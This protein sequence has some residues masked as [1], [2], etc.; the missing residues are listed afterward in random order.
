MIII[1]SAILMF[2]T[3]LYFVSLRRPIVYES[4]VVRGE[5]KLYF[6]YP[7]T[8][9]ILSVVG[10]HR[11][12]QPKN[13]ISDSIK[14]LKL[15]SRPEHQ[16]RLYLN[17]KL[18]LVIVILALFSALSIVSDVSSKLQQLREGRYIDRPEHG[19][20]SKE[21]MLDLRMESGEEAFSKD[22]NELSRKITIEV[23]ER[24]YSR[25]E[26]TKL[27][28]EGK[29]YLSEHVLGENENAEAIN[30]R[31]L[32]MDYVPNTEI[33][34]EWMPKDRNLILGD[35]TVKNEEL[36]EAI[37]TTVT[38]LLRYED[39]EASMTLPLRIIPKEYNDEEL[40]ERR[41]VAE[42][43]DAKEKSRRES[44]LTLPDRLDQYSLRWREDTTSNGITVLLFGIIIAFLAW[45]CMDLELKNQMKIRKE[46]LLLDYPE[47][48]N[49]FTLLVNAGMTVRQAFIKV[50]EDY[51]TN[52]SRRNMKLRYAYEEMLTT[53]HELKLGAA[54]GAAYEQYGRRLGL[55]PYIK[56]GS[57]ISQNRKKGNKGFTEMLRHEAL[58]AFEDRKEMAKRLGEEAGTKLLAPMMLLL[59][60]VFLLILIPAFLAFQI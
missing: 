17:Q 52:R 56:F 3:G 53:V 51:Q 42:L 45:Y 9:F 1:N 18:A 34:V 10:V 12:F 30:K 39:Q 58:E 11:S 22:R 23:E 40:L 50:A 41:L 43:Q 57:L 28:E 21:V 25:E 19:E 36:A 13:E 32:F 37:S 38:A 15:T 4:E 29:K 55:I 8:E 44:V 7:M 14:A 46:Q 26:I 49:K 35:G 54:E 2:L 60:I 6:L 48:I 31:L 16:Q 59:V 47:L 24:G 27:L 5:H 33:T 20:G